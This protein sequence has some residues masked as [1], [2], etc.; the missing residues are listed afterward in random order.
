MRSQCTTTKTHH[1]QKINK[2]IKFLKIELFYYAN[3]RALP[4]AALGIQSRPVGGGAGQVFAR[5]AGLA[6]EGP[7]RFPG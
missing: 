5:S 7:L 2:L 6:E 1:R 4:G 3:V